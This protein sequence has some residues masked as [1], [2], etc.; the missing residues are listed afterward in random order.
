MPQIGIAG[1][2]PPLV[3][4]VG[5][6]AE[7]PLTKALSLATRNLRLIGGPDDLGRQ[8]QTEVRQGGEVPLALLAAGGPG[9]TGGGALD[10]L[11]DG[12]FGGGASLPAIFQ[13]ARDAAAGAALMAFDGTPSAERHRQCLI[14]GARVYVPLDPCAASPWPLGCS[15]QS[16]LWRS[17]GRLSARVGGCLRC[18]VGAGLGA[19][20][21][22]VAR[23]LNGPE[24]SSGQ[25]TSWAHEMP[26]Q[27]PAENN[28]QGATALHGFETAAGVSTPQDGQDTGG[29]SGKAAG[30][31]PAPG[32]GGH[33]SAGWV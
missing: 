31:G 13:Q 15:L 25:K 10:G 3:R 6:F 14:S 22:T 12:P 8:R 9:E 21:S 17:G 29:G 19:D 16:K 20:V 27:V 7:A 33:A 11:S 4:T 28:D 18:W 5:K 24:M 23:A 1:P 30:L 26:K 32:D 2:T